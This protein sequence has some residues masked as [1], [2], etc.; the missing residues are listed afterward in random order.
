[1][2]LRLD[3]KL[4]DLYGSSLKLKDVYWKK[5]IDFFIKWYYTSD[6]IVIPKE[7]L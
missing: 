4:I 1:V 6:I 2:P 5:L 3:E 7:M